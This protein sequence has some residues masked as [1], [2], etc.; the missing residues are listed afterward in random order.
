MGRNIFF[1]CHLNFFQV[2]SA[3]KMAWNSKKNKNRSTIIHLKFYFLLPFIPNW[4]TLKTQV[5]SSDNLCL[6]FFLCDFLFYFILFLLLIYSFC[7]EDYVCSSSVIPDSITV[8]CL[9]HDLSWWQ[10]GHGLFLPQNINILLNLEPWVLPLK[11][12]YA[13]YMILHVVHRS[14]ISLWITCFDKWHCILY[15]YFF[16]YL[17]P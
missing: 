2:F 16:F 10:L 6:L 5:V 3:Q 13:S 9:I 15:E 8:P 12:N 17:G 1:I 4:L 14:S 7:C 11:R